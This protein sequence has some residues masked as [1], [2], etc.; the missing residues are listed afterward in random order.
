MNLVENTSSDTETR[1]F[2]WPKKRNY[3]KKKKALKEKNLRM[4]LLLVLSMELN[5]ARPISQAA[6]C[7][8]KIILSLMT[9]EIKH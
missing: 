6:L 1:F 3:L 7:F 9:I 4:N 2:G 5:P 8:L